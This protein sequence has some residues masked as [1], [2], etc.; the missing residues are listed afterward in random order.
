MHAKAGHG[1]IVG[2][3][4]EPGLGKS[5]LFYEFK[6]TSQSGCLLLE[7]YS[8]SY[9]KASP[10]LP[11][12][13][14]LKSYFQIQPQDEERTRRE[15]MIGK[16]LGLDRSLEDTLPYLFA[17]L[18]VDE[19]TSS[20]QQMDPQ[21][22]RR[23]TFDAVKKLFLRESLNQPLIL[24]FEDLHWIDTETQ[25]FLDVLSESVASAR[26][27]LLVNYRPEYRHEWG[28]KTYYIQLRLTPLGK[29]EAEEFLD[30][31]LGTTV[32]AR[33]ASPLHALKQLILAQTEGTP[34]FMEEV[35]QTLAEEGV[36]S[37][38]RG[39]YRLEHA[40]T[41]LHLSPTVQ[42]V[43]AARIDRLAADEKDLLHQ[44]AVMGRQ[45]P[46]SLVRQVVAQPEEALYHLVASLQRKEFL[47]EQPAL[48]EPD[49]IFK[50]ALT[51][52]VAYGTVL[53][54][55]RKALHERTAQ[56]ME[57]LYRATLDDHY[58]DLAHHYTRSG[59]T[60]KAVEYLR[61][62][63]EQATQRSAHAEA[64]THLATALELLN[65]LPDTPE[66]AQQE[67]TV[68][69]ARGAPLAVSKGYAAPEV[70]QAY[71]R[72]RE[73]CQQLGKTTELFPVLGG[74]LQISLVRAEY[75][76]ARELGEHLLTLAQD[77][78]DPALLLAAHDALGQTFFF[79]GEFALAQAH[80][81]QVLTGYDPQQH[82]ALT[83][84][85]GGE[86]PGVI[87]LNMVACV[88]WLLGY[89]DQ[90][91]QRIRK[92]LTLA[93]TLADPF[94]LALA[95]FGAALF[96]QFRREGQDTQEQA[97]ALL[98]LSTEQEFPF[99]LALGTVLQGW[100]L[101]EQGQGE[102]GI[103]QLRHGLAAS[104]ATGV[105]LQRSY[106]L[107][108]LAE[109]YGKAG[110]AEAGLAALTEA[111]TV[112]DKSSERFYEAELYR[113]K[114]ELALQSESQSS[115][116]P[117]REAEAYFQRAIAVARHQSA[118]SLELRAVMSL[119]RLWQRQ[120][121]TDEARQ[122]LAEIYDWFTEGFETKDLQEAK[123]LLDVLAA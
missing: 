82:R 69:I 105:E 15:K 18:G 5:R 41:E 52:E 84:L 91:L 115:E 34:F 36:L 27:L 25:G 12:L 62:A 32:G 58:S 67:L 74:L 80:L 104:Q 109:A 97:E 101:A 2:V 22:R 40:P 113:L 13:E 79:L 24:I 10:Y 68:Q 20:L 122:I 112:V 29:A 31:L 92:S 78:H 14:L 42:G 117:P 26:I 110:Q 89:P 93:R 88:W 116:S 4:G 77:A 55:R 48:P 123:A 6:L 70:G 71:T 56:A 64:L 75:Q 54:E 103:V 33:H 94:S 86:D 73:L 83:L 50:H 100:A 44:L 102:E 35:V 90:A 108:L 63:G 60:Q 95:L 59:N 21:I 23:R 61:L 111:L 119:S 81:E 9:G 3:M 51:Q 49:Y 39:Q 114:G 87:C 17:L 30:V 85:L 96:H 57:T 98:R 43:L 19:P 118:K 28:S 38:E 1:Q 99:W 53:H 107:A 76:R 45:F 66:R 7:A 16:V 106:W 65:T 46:L 37:G 120:G 72:A 8:V 47:Y 121:K 11:L